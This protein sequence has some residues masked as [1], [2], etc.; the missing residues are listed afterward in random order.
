MLRVVG[1]EALLVFGYDSE[2]VA[3]ILRSGKHGNDLG[4]VAEFNELFV[5]YVLHS[6]DG[7]DTQFKL[8]LLA[9]M[10]EVF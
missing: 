4:L 1:F 8:S 7:I 9:V 5:V 10:F 3:Y 2:S 6:E